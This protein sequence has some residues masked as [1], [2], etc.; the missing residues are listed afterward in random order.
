MH[1]V[2]LKFIFGKPT[3]I[4]HDPVPTHRLQTQRVSK[5]IEIFRVLIYWLRK[6]KTTQIRFRDSITVQVIT[7]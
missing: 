7:V 5:F 1:E 4:F 6:F 3:R 2:Q